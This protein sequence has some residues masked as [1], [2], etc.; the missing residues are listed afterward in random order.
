MSASLCSEKNFY[1]QGQLQKSTEEKESVGSPD[2]D[3]TVIAALV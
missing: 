3:N 1:E 2:A